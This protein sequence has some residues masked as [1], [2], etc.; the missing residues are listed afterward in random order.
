M[1][2][3]GRALVFGEGRKEKVPNPVQQ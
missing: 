2:E 3:K 1:A